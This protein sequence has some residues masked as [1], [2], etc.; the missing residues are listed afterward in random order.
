M[1]T[2]TLVAGLIALVVGASAASAALVMVLWN[3]VMVSIF[4]LPTIS[5][6]LAWGLMIL[7][8]ILFKSVTRIITKKG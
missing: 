3:W 5:F 1:K 8:G 2:L 6:W 4:G 7:C